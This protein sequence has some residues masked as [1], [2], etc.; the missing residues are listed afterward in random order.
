[1]T[2]QERS[3]ARYR[4]SLPSLFPQSTTPG[5]LLLGASSSRLTVDN[6]TE[7]AFLTWAEP[8]SSPILPSPIPVQ[9]FSPTRANH[10]MG[11]RCAIWAFQRRRKAN[12]YNEMAVSEW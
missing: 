10:A 2:R 3:G 1:M 12:G 6:A 9:P 7:R 8:P 11:H 5:T 4:L